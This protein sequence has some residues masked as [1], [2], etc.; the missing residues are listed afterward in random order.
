ML[1]SGMQIGE[2]DILWDAQHFHYIALS[3]EILKSGLVPSNELYDTGIVNYDT[4]INLM[5]SGGDL[6]DTGD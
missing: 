6:Y 1:R 4:E 5:G 2:S 3:E